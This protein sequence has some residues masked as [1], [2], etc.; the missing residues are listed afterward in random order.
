MAAMRRKLEDIAS[1][2]IKISLSCRDCGN[3]RSAQQTV[4]GPC[5]PRILDGVE[6]PALLLLSKYHTIDGMS[7]PWARLS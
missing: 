6:K 4:A 3:Q 7:T 2:F 1:F 5:T